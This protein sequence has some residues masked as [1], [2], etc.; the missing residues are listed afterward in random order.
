ML[1]RLAKSACW[2]RKNSLIKLYTRFDFG[3]QK[4]QQNNKTELIPK[5]NPITNEDGKNQTGSVENHKGNNLDKINL[6]GE[7]ENEIN[8]TPINELI[9]KANVNQFDKHQ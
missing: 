4:N 5:G 6:K 9:K 1:F 7:N 2:H 3:S 8:Q